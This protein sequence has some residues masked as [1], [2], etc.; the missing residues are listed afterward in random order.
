[1]RI[2]DCFFFFPSFFP[3]FLSPSSIFLRDENEE[4]ER[5]IWEDEEREAVEKI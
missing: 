2:R 1:M 4:G 5:K 3:F